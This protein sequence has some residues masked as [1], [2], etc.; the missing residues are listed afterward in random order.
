METSPPI[1][2]K[3]VIIRKKGKSQSSHSLCN[4]KTQYQGR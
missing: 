4:I 3:V 1:K 2:V